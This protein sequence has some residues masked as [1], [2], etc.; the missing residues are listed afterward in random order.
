LQVIAESFLFPFDS[1][2]RWRAAV[3]NP[4]GFGAG[5]TS[6]AKTKR[7]LPKLPPGS[8]A[9]IHHHWD[10]RGIQAVGVRWAFKAKA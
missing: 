2:C 7:R 4:A 3:V 9:L 5:L 10:L 8:R 6:A 1:Q